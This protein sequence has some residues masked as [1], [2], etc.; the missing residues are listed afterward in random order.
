MRDPDPPK[1][2]HGFYLKKFW[3]FTKLGNL[4]IFFGSVPIF[5]QVNQPLNLGRW[6]KSF[7]VSNFHLWSG[8][9][10]RVT[11][12]I[13]HLYIYNINQGLISIYSY[14]S[15]WSD[16]FRQTYPTSSPVS[17]PKNTPKQLMPTVW[18]GFL[19]KRQSCGSHLPVE[20]V[21]PWKLTCPKKM[22]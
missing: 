18:H 19:L 21:H 3:K 8:I 12:P 9:S 22:D 15:T 14:S 7:R 1:L 6:K 4:F 5:F 11:V 16:F 17:R 20:H 10:V 2:N 13:H